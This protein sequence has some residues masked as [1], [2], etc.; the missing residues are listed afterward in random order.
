MSKFDEYYAT[1][2]LAEQQ[3]IQESIKTTLVKE[4]EDNFGQLLVKYYDHKFSHDD[5]L[6][7]SLIS[8]KMCEKIQPIDLKQIAN[9]HYLIGIIY[10]KAGHDD[11]ALEHFQKAFDHYQKALSFFE[12]HLPVEFDKITSIAYNLFKIYLKKNDYE[13]AM[14]FG[15]KAVNINPKISEKYSTDEEGAA[16]WYFDTG[17]GLMKQEPQKSFELIEKSLEIRQKLFNSDNVN[18]AFCHQ[19]IGAIHQSYK[20]NFDKS[21]EHYQKAIEIYSKHLLDENKES[22]QYQGRIQKISEEVPTIVKKRFLK[23]IQDSITRIFS[24][25]WRKNKIPDEVAVTESPTGGSAT[26]QYDIKKC[27]ATCLLNIGWCHLQM[28]ELHYDNSMDYYS[29]ALAIYEEEEEVVSNKESIAQCYQ[30]MGYIRFSKGQYD[31][32]IALLNKSIENRSSSS[33]SSEH[34]KNIAICHINLGC[35]YYH[36]KKYQRALEHALQA[37]ETYQQDECNNGIMLGLI[38]KNIAEYNCK[39][40]NYGQA[41]E[42][43]LKAKEIKGN[44]DATIHSTLALIYSNQHLFNKAVEHCN[45][46][47]DLVQQD[48]SSDH[49]ADCYERLGEVY[50]DQNDR[51]K[52]RQYYEKALDIYKKTLPSDH[53]IINRTVEILD[54]L[55]ID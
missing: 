2:K 33:S 30:D 13:N 51:Q 34:D 11:W 9:L 24:F 54:N 10:S 45:K 25:L 26:A 32:S 16:Q 28:G 42:F 38:Y 50:Q 55:L 7:D 6:E 15:M 49:N 31:K 29:K 35:C 46:T 44:D 22:S 23:S 52:A 27:Y 12:I 4:E 17:A 19:N 8:L 20:S 21:I 41:L 1:K 48:P 37:M 18:I 36:Q 47:L 5:I 43:I 39:L 3:A 53:P 40:E 14:T